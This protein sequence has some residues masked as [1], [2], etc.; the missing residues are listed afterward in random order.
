MTSKS[1]T[2]KTKAALPQ[3][4][5]TAKPIS[6]ST[7]G[8]KAAAEKREVAR[9]ATEAGVRSRMS[10]STRIA[11]PQRKAAADDGQPHSKAFLARQ[12]FDESYAQNPPPARKEIIQRAVDE[13]NLT[14][15]AANTYLQN[16]R[17]DKGMVHSR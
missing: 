1:K 9:K 11:N 8:K 3:K 12:I 15:A 4:K 17:T 2:A 14:P 6:A 7:Q 10:N 16:Y 13:A 5:S